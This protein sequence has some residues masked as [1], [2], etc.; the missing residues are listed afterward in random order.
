MTVS[1]LFLVPL[2][3]FL[4]SYIANRDLL[5]PQKYF[6]FCLFVYFLALSFNAYAPVLLVVFLVFNMLALIFLALEIFF[7]PEGNAG[8]KGIKYAFD[9]NRVVAFVYLMSLVPIGVQVYQVY[10]A[11][12][13]FSYLAEIRLR[14]KLWEGQGYI[15]IFKRMMPLANMIF[16]FS[17]LVYTGRVSK[18]IWGFYALH[19][20]LVI[21]MGLLSGSRG[22]ALFLFMFVVIAVGVYQ[23]KIRLGKSVMILVL[24]LV[25]AAVLGQV[26][27][28]NVSAEGGF[29]ENVRAIDLSGVQ[30]FSYGVTPLQKYFQ[31]EDWNAQYGMTF[32]SALTNFVPR[33]IWPSKPDPG[34]VVLTKGVAGS[35]YS[36][37][38][39][40]SPGLFVESMLNF[41]AP[42][43][44][45]V[46]CCM[47]SVIFLLSA[48]FYARFRN[49]QDLNYYN[50]LFR[51]IL[52]V[53]TFTVPGGLLFG[54]FSSVVNGL[55]IKILFSLFLIFVLR[56]LFMGR[57]Y[58]CVR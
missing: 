55:L 33:A 57:V 16:L 45:A 3:I 52:F 27:N 13:L 10:S 49:D 35:N 39:N 26:R 30:M 2:S 11:G 32:I 25:A 37:T 14:V 6:C 29:G 7:I 50:E 56:F 8:V 51:F 46:F 40:Y 15:L 21:G 18:W 28:I 42:L 58:A 5:S 53:L 17:N 20:L 1:A 19:A 47:F 12:G 43:G 44:A 23:H 9:L 54:E 41:G 24:V 34:G 48:R 4:L 22:S 38:T 36:G 31:K